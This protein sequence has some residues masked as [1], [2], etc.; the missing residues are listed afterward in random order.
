MA[1]AAECV[2]APL[3]SKARCV[4]ALACRAVRESR[5]KELPNPTVAIVQRDLEAT[6]PLD[7][8]LVARSPLKP[9]RVLSRGSWSSSTMRSPATARR[10]P[11]GRVLTTL[12]RE[13]ALPLGGCGEAT[14]FRPRSP[15]IWQL[16]KSAARRPLRQWASC[17]QDR[18]QKG[19]L[20]HALRGSPRRLVTE[21][22]TRCE[23]FI[24][25]SSEHVA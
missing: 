17:L 4:S 6:P 8:I 11:P 14:E 2:T 13:L 3:F 19:L 1:R 7:F 16:V 12:S 10:R 21:W 18:T 9:D 22:S 24:R 23:R 5:I 20:G 25:P 15:F